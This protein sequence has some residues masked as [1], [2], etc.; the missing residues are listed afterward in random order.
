[1][2]LTC[3]LGGGFSAPIADPQNEEG[4][5]ERPVLRE[6]PTLREQPVEANEPQE[7]LLDIPDLSGVPDLVAEIPDLG[8]KIL[9][10]IP[11]VNGFYLCGSHMY[12]PVAIAQAVG[13]GNALRIAGETLGLQS[14]PHR[15][16]NGEGFIYADRGPY[17][18]FPVMNYGKL[19]SG[20]DPLADRVVFNANDGSF[21]DVLHHVGSSFEQC[22]RKTVADYYKWKT[23]ILKGAKK[24]VDVAKSAI[25]VAGDVV[26]VAKPLVQG[27]TAGAVK[28]VV[29]KAANKV[30]DT[31]VNKVAKPILRG[32]REE[33]ET[34][35]EDDI[36]TTPA[37]E[38][39]ADTDTTGTD[40]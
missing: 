34:T 18:E 19:F 14:Y 7:P 12:T 5:P 11:V 22:D 33:P 25:D 15:F 8:Q 6:R 23:P 20:D 3:L 13:F 17:M 37:I 16:N 31:V 24:A 4:Q 40:D 30:V 26:D 2:I 39:G 35:E 32:N 38:P 21:V 28:V 1:M 9:Q 36:D 27:D 10:N 29:D